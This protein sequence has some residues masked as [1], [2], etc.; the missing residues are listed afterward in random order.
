MYTACIHYRAHAIVYFMSLKF[1]I[2]FLHK[3]NNIWILDFLQNESYDLQH[4]LRLCYYILINRWLCINRKWYKSSDN[5]SYLN[6][7]IK[8]W[9][10]WSNSLMIYS[11][12]WL[13]FAYIFVRMKR[14]ER[15]FSRNVYLHNFVG[16]DL[17]IKNTKWF[18]AFFFAF[19]HSK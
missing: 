8:W 13:H 3:W 1:Q 17:S 9:K 16:T 18:C 6:G 5:I 4:F 19:S 7:P 12:L 14:F 10:L 2:F 15:I 11:R